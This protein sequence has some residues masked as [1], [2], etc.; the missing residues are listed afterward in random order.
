V[1]QELILKLGNISAISKAN[2][3]SGLT[4]VLKSDEYGLDLGDNL[5]EEAEKENMLKELEYAKGFKISVEKKL[6]NERFV[7]NAN[8]EVV[9][10]ERDK[11]ADAESKIKAIE[12][13]LAKLA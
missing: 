5:D 3:V 8:A 7:N 10:R 4:M 9:Q 2:A 11:L 1:L 13:A 12:E 6:G